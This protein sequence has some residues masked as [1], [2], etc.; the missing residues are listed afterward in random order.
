M[1][2]SVLEVLANA[3]H[4]LTNARIGFQLA[5]GTEQLRN[6]IKQLEKNPDAS[7]EFV[8]GAPAEQVESAGTSA[9]SRV[10]KRSRVASKRTAS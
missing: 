9:N 2:L 1:S 10:T 7:A 8:E 5:I 6:A 4:N 3:E